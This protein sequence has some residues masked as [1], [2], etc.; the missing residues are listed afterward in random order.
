MAGSEGRVTMLL[1][2]SGWVLAG[3]VLAAAG[4]CSFDGGGPTA[5]GRDGST[6]DGGGSGD[7]GGGTDAGDVCST[8]DPAAPFD[9]C[10]VSGPGG[11]LELLED[12][13]YFYDTDTDVLTFEDGPPIPH[14]AELIAGDTIRVVVAGHLEIGEMATLRPTGGL[15]LLF[16]V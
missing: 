5:G 7:G 2:R 15:P 12:G 16:V 6:G 8:W 4:G 3:V 10:E 13:T 1:A 9:P 11:D 14:Q